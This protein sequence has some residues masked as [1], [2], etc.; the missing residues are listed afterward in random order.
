[1]FYDEIKEEENRIC[2][3]NMEWRWRNTVHKKAF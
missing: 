3:K 2:S 1:M